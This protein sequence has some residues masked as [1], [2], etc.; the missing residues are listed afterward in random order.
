VP[1]GTP[2]TEERRRVDRCRRAQ[3]EVEVVDEPEDPLILNTLREDPTNSHESRRCCKIYSRLRPGNPPQLEKARELFH[4][5]FFDATRY[6]LGRVGRFR[7]NR[8]FG[9][10]DPEDVQMT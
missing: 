4:E 1:H 6:R 7:L 8:K 2:I 5:K 3:A 10:D 9:Q